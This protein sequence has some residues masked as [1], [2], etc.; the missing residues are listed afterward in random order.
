[1]GNEENKEMLAT[2]GEIT[3]K[4]EN[5]FIGWRTALGVTLGTVTLLG[6]ITYGGWEL[7]NS[8]NERT[9]T[10]KSETKSDMKD[11]EARLVKTQDEIKSEMKEMRAEMKEMKAELLGAIKAKK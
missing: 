1:M 5:I 9:N 3:N 2:K 6:I 7:Y 8:A 10:F 11:L 4:V